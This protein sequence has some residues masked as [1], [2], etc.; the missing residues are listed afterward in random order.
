MTAPTILQGICIDSTKDGGFIFVFLIIMCL[1][2]GW[3]LGH[4]WKVSKKLEKKIE[5]WKNQ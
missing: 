5:K 1:L 3:A 2:I 4:D